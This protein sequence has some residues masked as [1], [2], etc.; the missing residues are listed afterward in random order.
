MVLER[1]HAAVA[2]LFVVAIV[3]QVFLAGAALAN[4]GGSGNFSTHMEFGYT[5]I[6]IVALA[7]LVTALVARRPRRD[8]GIVAAIFVLYVVQTMLPG[9]RTSAPWIA[10]LHPVNALF[11]FAL[12][13]W[14]ARRTWRAA[15]A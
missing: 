5:W 11:L 7:L 14:Y 13:V 8:V 2:G 10:A 4:L 12:A 15:M 1:V 9:A 3:V 6:G